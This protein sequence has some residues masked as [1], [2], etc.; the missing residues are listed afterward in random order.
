MTEELQT[1]VGR[2]VIDE[3]ESL[4]ERAV[5]LAET[6]AADLTGNVGWAL[7]GGSTPAAFYRACLGKGLIPESLLARTVWTASDE[8]IVPLESVESNFG[9]AARQLL[10]PLKVTD[11]C[12]VPWPTDLPPREA[13]LVYRD[14]WS[15]KIGVGRVFDICFLGMG[16]DCHTASLFPGSPL[17]RTEQER[18]FAAVEVPGKG[19]RL[20]VTSEGIMRA[21]L[22]VVMALGEGKAKALREVV[23]GDEDRI[24]KPAQLLAGAA[25]RVV[26]LVDHGA[27]SRIDR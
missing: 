14:R 6:H 19:W 5:D 25:D 3:A 24:E 15:A 11:D 23:Y 21:G 4:F 7:T 10:D 17:L 20:T 1:R 13:A 16:D 8:R 12:R 22:L 2:I 27:A 9:N 18:D 26:W